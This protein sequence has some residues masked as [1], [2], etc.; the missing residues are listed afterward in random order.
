MRKSVLY[1]CSLA[2]FTY[3]FINFLFCIISAFID[4]GRPAKNQLD[5]NIVNDII[6]TVTKFC[7][8]SESVVRNAIT[9]KC[10]DE[11]KMSRQRN[12]KPRGG[13]VKKDVYENNKE[14]SVNN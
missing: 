3:L 9:T 13:N 12:E 1:P 14:N 2:Q 6:Q 8:V 4:R 7:N 10:A 11:N 5:P